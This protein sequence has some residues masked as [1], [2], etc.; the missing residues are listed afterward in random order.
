MNEQALAWAAAKFAELRPKNWQGALGAIEQHHEQL[1][2]LDT[3]PATDVQARIIFDTH[4]ADPISWEFS[5]TIIRMQLHLGIPLHPLLARIAA[6]M[7]DGERPAWDK[8]RNVN[9]DRDCIAIAMLEGLRD[10][11]GIKPTR[12]PVSSAICG[13]DLVV[14]VMNRHGLNVTVEGIIKV[15]TNRKLYR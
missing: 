9:Y 3:L 7:I 10:H 6:L 15:W 1:A 11:F 4:L 12:N 13:A 2:G 14:E 8:G 5:K